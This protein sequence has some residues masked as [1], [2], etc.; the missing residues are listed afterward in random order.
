MENNLEQIQLSVRA[1]RKYNLRFHGAKC[2]WGEMS[3]RRSP[4][5]YEA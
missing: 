1:D 3:V 5:T 2:P 4:D